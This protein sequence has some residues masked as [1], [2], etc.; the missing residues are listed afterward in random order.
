MSAEDGL[1]ARTRAFGLHGRV[2]RAGYGPEGQGAVPVSDDPKDP[3]A[4]SPAGD[5]REVPRAARLAT[6]S[7]TRRA[8]ASLLN[9]GQTGSL[10]FDERPNLGLR[11]THQLA[12]V[13][14]QCRLDLIEAQAQTSV[15]LDIDGPSYR[16]H[17]ARQ[18]AEAGTTAA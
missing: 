15:R 6:G 16:R 14:I 18:R 3:E 5:Y 17:L 13:P 8:A 4:A 10:R 11:D 1:V 7:A 2:G 9:A 12:V